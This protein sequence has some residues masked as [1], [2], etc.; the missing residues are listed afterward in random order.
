MCFRGEPRRIGK[1]YA[2]GPQGLRCGGGGD[3]RPG[4][5]RRRAGGGAAGR[6]AAAG[7]A[8][9]GADESGHAAGSDQRRDA[10]VFQ[11]A[12]LR[13]HLRLSRHVRPRS[14]RHARRTQA[15]EGSGRGARRRASRW[16]PCRS[17]PA[18]SRRLENPNIMLGKSPE[19]DREID[20]ICQM[21][22]NAARAGIPAVKYNMTV[23]G[24]LRTG[25][26]AG[27]GGTV[28]STFVYAKARQEPPLTEAGPVAGRRDVGADHLLPGARGAGG[29]GVQG[30]AGLPSARPRHA[31]A[32][33][34]RRPPRARA[35]STG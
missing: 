1:G 4:Q 30:P 15:V 2:D 11:A 27:R 8:P 10:P 34:P 13:P 14:V 32:G 5:G 12:R 33:L 23:L 3:T 19:R 25:S 28:Y 31:A 9:A 26:T 17:A 22:R 20:H 6:G 16:C 29:R 24:V 35:P 18:T 21:I 7:R